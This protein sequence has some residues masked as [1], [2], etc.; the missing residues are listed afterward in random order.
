MPATYIPESASSSAA[1]EAVS[2]PAAA[3]VER[4]DTRTGRSWRFAVRS[5]WFWCSIA[6]CLCWTGW[7]LTARL[8]TKHMPATTM[9][10]ISTFGFL[11]VTV[12]AVLTRRTGERDLLGGAYALIS[13]IL[14]GLGGVALYEAYRVGRNASVITATSSLY[15]IVTV[16]C[17]VIVLRERLSWIQLL[18]LIFAVIAILALSV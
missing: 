13:G 4:S 7:A 1:R 12:L 3:P 11:F 17:A 14:L 16:A 15:P 5:K 18:G 2:S 9:E 8:G 6:S 10:F